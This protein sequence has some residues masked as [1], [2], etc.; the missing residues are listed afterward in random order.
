ML[1]VHLLI[2]SISG[3]CIN[4]LGDFLIVYWLLLVKFLLL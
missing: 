3:H 2:I 1:H 4:V